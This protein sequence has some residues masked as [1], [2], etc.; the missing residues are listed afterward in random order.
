MLTR[1]QHLLLLAPL[2]AILVP[3][4]IW[5]AVFGFVAS[6]TD[7]Q[8][9][10]PNTQF[11]GL[12]NYADVLDDGEFRAAA[13]NIVLFSVVTITLELAIGLGIAY[14]LREPFRGRGIVRVALLLPWLVSPVASGVMWHFLFNNDLGLLNFWPATL[15]LSR[16]P[17]PLSVNL[18]LWST[19]A[20][21]IWRKAPFVSFLAL[22][23][24]LAIPVEQWDLARVEGVPLLTQFRHIVLPRLRVLLLTITL[25]LVGD[26]LGTFESILMLTGGGPGEATMTPGFYSY[27]R[28]FIAYNWV[29][30]A[31]SGWFIVLAMLLVGF[32]YLFLA[33]REAE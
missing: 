27:K 14:L 6:F 33:R 7:Y 1:R 5:P 31:T 18:A 8:P 2:I 3:F 26:A 17:Y 16:L 11:V 10:Q 13:S 29:D 23:G 19:M 15:G 4:L 24:L 20:T 32:C 9:F 12:N 21:E 25:L 22:P 30:G 28:A